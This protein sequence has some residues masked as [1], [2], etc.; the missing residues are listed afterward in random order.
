MSEIKSI[1]STTKSKKDSI[2][3][4][5][6]YIKELSQG[7]NIDLLVDFNTNSENAFINKKDT[8][9]RV[10]LNKKVLQFKNIIDKQFKGEFIYVK[11][12]TSGHVFHGIHKINDNDYH[13]AVKIVAYPQRE[14][15][16]NI[17]DTRRP[18][19]AEIMIIKAL[20]YFILNRETP[21]IVLPIF[22]FYTDITQC[23]DL[24]KDCKIKHSRYKKFID[25]YENNDFYNKVS[26]LISEWAN[27]GDLLDFI[28]K[29]YLK[30]TPIYW[31]VI[32]FQIISTLAVIQSKY[33]TFRHNDLKLNNILMNKI[34]LENNK[35]NYTIYKIVKSEYKVPNI[36]YQIKIWDFDF[37]CIEP[38]IINEKVNMDWTK[39]INITGI[40]NRYYDLHYMFNT[41]IRKEFFPE[42]MFSQHVPQELKDFINRVIPDKYKTGEFIHE[43]GRILINDEYVIPDTLLKS[44]P[45]FDELRMS[46]SF[47]LNIF[48]N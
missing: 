6:D 22:N 18:E 10:R 23:I 30:F 27:K 1:I 29:N 9:A 3:M 26:I 34:N 31:K 4:R 2:I 43:R 28:K 14:K 45:Y 19:N 42:I 24:L 17:Y 12:G 48:L 33:P 25:R 38:Y 39:K 7:K 8:D 16:S 41:L 11:S 44:D 35:S 36:G 46:N 32:F 5:I 15:Y 13:Y 21:H 40:K 47:D 37:A 20:S